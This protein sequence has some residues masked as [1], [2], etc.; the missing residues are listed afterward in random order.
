MARMARRVWNGPYG[1]FGDRGD[2]WQ[3]RHTGHHMRP[4]LALPSRAAWWLSWRAWR[5]GRTIPEV[6]SEV[7]SRWA[8]QRIA[9][10]GRTDFDDFARSIPYN[11]PELRKP[12]SARE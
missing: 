9:E 3:M 2:L 6:I 5:T 10:M 12:H 8:D 7:V 4:H 11:R 1:R